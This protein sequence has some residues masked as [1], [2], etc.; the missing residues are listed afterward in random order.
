M[1]KSI[2]D[3]FT[4]RLATFQEVM[5][6]NLEA[7]EYDSDN[8]MLYIQFHSGSEYVFLDVPQDVYEE[9]MEADSHGKY[10][11]KHIRDRYEYHRI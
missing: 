11:W 4:E 10:F 7:V 3:R 5:S 8:A 6:S 2:L 9:L 1:F